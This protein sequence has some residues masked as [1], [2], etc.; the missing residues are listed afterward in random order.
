MDFNTGS[1]GGRPEDQSRPLYGGESGG[2][3]PRGPAASP[4]GEFNFQD[5]V[6]SFISTARGV[7]LSPVAF[8]RGI[9]RQGDFINPAAFALI[10]YMIYAILAGIIGLVFGSVSSL[11]S[12]TDQE[13][14]A[15]VAGSVGGFVLGLILAPFIAAVILLIVA[16]VRHLLVMLIVGAGNAGFEAT[17]RVSS[18]TFATRLIWWIPILGTIIGFVYGL[19]LSVIGVREVHATT[20]GKAALIVLIPVVVA[21]I[22]LALLAALVGAAIFTLLQQQ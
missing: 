6:G 18:Y 15:G 20:T 19:V 14:A 17:L 7:L 11:T 21:T 1:S 9:A 5:P 10:N 4:G 13:A 3:P 16:G 8:F 2:Q 12:A 22:L